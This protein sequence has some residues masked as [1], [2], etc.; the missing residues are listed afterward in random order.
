[1]QATVTVDL[2]IF[3]VRDERL[4][5]LLVQRGKPPFLGAWALPG[6]FVE[7]EEDLDQA[8]QRELDE[9]TGL[10]AAKLHVEQLGA[11]GAPGRDPRGRIVTVAYVALMPD[12]PLPTAGGDARAARWAPVQAVLGQ[13]IAVAFDHHRILAEALGRVR[14]KLEYTTLGAAFCPEE[15]TIAE[16]R[17]VYE[18]VW[19]QAL[20]PRNFHRKV[21]SVDGFLIPT[22]KKTHRDGGRPAALYHCGPATLLHP[23]I[24]AEPTRSAPGAVSV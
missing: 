22:G 19:G 12:L 3:T 20:D 2:A 7:G 17:R 21:T 16:L 5:V 9:E 18:I 1:M 15:F 24:P 23:S 11:Y 6:G 10:D 8:A 4:N 13:A 14:H